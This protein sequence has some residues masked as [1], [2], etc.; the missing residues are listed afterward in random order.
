MQA[1]YLN[2][3]NQKADL[4][5]VLRHCRWTAA[6]LNR[7]PEIRFKAELF[8]AYYMSEVVQIHSDYPHQYHISSS[9]SAVTGQQAI[10]PR[11]QM[12]RILSASLDLGEQAPI[13]F[14]DIFNHRYY[15]FYCDSQSYFEV[16][17]Q[18]ENENYGWE[19]SS[20]T[21]SESLMSFIGAQNQSGGIPA[22]HLLQYTGLMGLKN[23]HPAVLQQILADYFEMPFEIEISGLEFQ[24]ITPS[25]LTQLGTK[26]GQNQQ[27]GV[28]AVIGKTAPLF[29]QVL[30]I[31][32]CPESY[33]DAPKIQSD[34]NFPHVL[35]QLVS[36]SMEGRQRY[37]LRL[38]VNA[39]HLPR[40]SLS[41]KSILGRSTWLASM[42]NDSVDDANDSQIEDEAT[43]AFIDLPLVVEED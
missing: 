8:P 34:V 14:F 22:F 23:T 15:Q 33:S 39:K 20:L 37:R 11:Q 19:K 6:Q 25:A 30:T 40:L 41:H 2:V 18:F 1:D 3:L 27:L 21:F 7:I 43:S 5:A 16:T 13:D 42:Q 17:V 12:M 38:K 31:R 24:L 4:T 36:L 28:S 10:L 29:G 26:I 35:N 32:V 9:L